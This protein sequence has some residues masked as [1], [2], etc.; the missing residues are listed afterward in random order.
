MLTILKKKLFK[1]YHCNL[2]FLNYTFIFIIIYFPKAFYLVFNFGQ[3]LE[4]IMFTSPF[5][6]IYDLFL[7]ALRNSEE[8]YTTLV[9]DTTY[10][11]I[12]RVSFRIQIG[13]TMIKKNILNIS[14]KQILFLIFVVMVSIILVNLLIA[15][16]TNTYNITTEL[17][18][19]WLR[20][21]SVKKIN[22]KFWINFTSWMLV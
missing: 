16:M 2:C 9:H 19:E 15:M 5:Q 6:S 7:L 3:N 18:R 4:L 14:K 22:W 10:H 20:Q 12:G 8:I 21:V 17:K 13:F 1:N 11:I